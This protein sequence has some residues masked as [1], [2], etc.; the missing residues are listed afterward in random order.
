MANDPNSKGEEGWKEAFSKN[1]KS[2]QKESQVPIYIFLCQSG[3]FVISTLVY[4][5]YL[6]SDVNP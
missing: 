6:K 5:S 1:P 2:L 3:Q 4:Q